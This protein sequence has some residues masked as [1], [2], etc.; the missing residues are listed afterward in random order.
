MI[1]I[2]RDIT[3]PAEKPLLMAKAFQ[4]NADGS[5]VV[6]MP[7]GTFAYQIPSDGGD[8]YGKFGFDPSPTGAYQSC[9][10]SGQL[11]SFWTRQQDLPYV[12]SWMELP[13]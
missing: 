2:K 4:T 1:C 6:L 8:S 9:K 7:D 3:N 10:V 13:N 5:T 12:Y 11:V